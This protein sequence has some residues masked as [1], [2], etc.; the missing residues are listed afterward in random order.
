MPQ[1]VAQLTVEFLIANGI[2]NLYCLPGVQND[3]FFDALYHRQD[4]LRPIHTRHEQGAAYMALG[5]ALAT[6]EPQAFS[7]VPGPGF[8]NGCAAL[9]TAYALN[10]PVFALIGQIPSNA[11]GR[12]GGVLHE[13]EG[14]LETLQSLT[15]H[16]DRVIDGDHAAEQLSTAWRAML[17][18]R[19]RPAGLEVPADIW[20][21]EATFDP[22]DLRVDPPAR[23][24]ADPGS[25]EE[26]AR[27]IDQA[28][29]PLIA[30]GGGARDCGEEV[31][32]LARSI[33]AGVVAH[34]TG[35]GVMPADDPLSIGLPQAHALWPDCDLVIGLGTRLMMQMQWGFDDDLKI[36]QVDVDPDMLDK[37]R[38]ATVGIHA[39]LTHALPDLNATIARSQPSRD[40]WR[41]RIVEL[42]EA[43]DH[44]R[45]LA[46]QIE[47][48]SA[49]R[50][51][52]P[53]D[54]ILVD[55]MTQIAYVSR[56]AYPVHRPRTYLST[57]Y[58]GTLGWGLAA[59]LGAAHAR[60]DVPVVSING[61]GGALFC[62]AELATARHHAIPLT[63]IVMKDDAYGN[64]RGFQRDR[65]DAR[66]IASDLSSPDFV[67]LA[68][69]FGVRG[70]RAETPDEL[71]R[72]LREA[73]A[74]DGPVV[75]EVP[76]GEFPSP[77]KH[78]HLPKVR[79]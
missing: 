59:G 27:L 3:P 43:P 22:L 31:A 76:V 61:D 35:H 30:V 73:I 65:F 47:W 40:E 77:W 8:L 16:A 15:K 44:A 41:A 39:D 64:V 26:A 52:M 14:Q 5:A 66:Y 54:G 23:L 28:R 63:V 7:I 56:I 10:A 53:E 12:R 49:I 78:L 17:S 72:H 24:P 36:V 29:R 70:V 11:I 19:Q 42:H 21:R 37:F 1:T 13:I 69:S 62:I 74:F 67:K 50:E 38:P 60:R 6:G 51:V 75:I 55:E 79:G 71:R 32:R 25:I 46:P 4:A 48:L 57:G 20:N 34:R 18:E 58:Q 2:D 9:A 68:E 45:D 33:S